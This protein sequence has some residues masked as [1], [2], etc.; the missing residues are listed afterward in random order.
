MIRHLIISFIFV[1]IIGGSLLLE[2][3]RK[4]EP[5]VFNT[6]IQ[7]IVPPGF[8]APVYN[9]QMNPLSQEGI[10]LGKNY[11]MM[12]ACPLMAIFPVPPVTSRKRHSPLLITTAAMD[13]TIPIL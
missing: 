3:C 2:G 1:F 13:I 4:S 9:F 7:F 11:S 10:A 12:A 8:P 5:P 6:R